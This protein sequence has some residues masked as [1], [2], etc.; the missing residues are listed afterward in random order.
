MYEQLTQD[1]M[2]DHLI[3]T[4][5]VRTQRPSGQVQFETITRVEV[6]TEINQVQVK[7]RGGTVFV[8]PR[9]TPVAIKKRQGK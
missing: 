9:L 8:M 2:T 1:I 3:P 4:D 7:L 5:M 6:D